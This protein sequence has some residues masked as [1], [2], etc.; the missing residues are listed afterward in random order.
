MEPR[1]IP[2]AI[3]M[4]SESMVVLSSP[5]SS[6]YALMRSPHPQPVEMEGVVKEE[7]SSSPIGD[8]GSKKLNSVEE[9]RILSSDR[10]EVPMDFPWETV[11]SLRK[12]KKDWTVD[13]IPLY[14][15]W[16]HPDVDVASCYCTMEDVHT[17]R[18]LVLQFC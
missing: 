17:L 2:L 15:S 7:V 9:G 1:S 8:D 4:P 12:P 10:S 6:F 18:R 13:C 11:L 5:S 16:V 3:V 14:Y